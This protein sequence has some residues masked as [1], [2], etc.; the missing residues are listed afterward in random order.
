MEIERITT[1][2]AIAMMNRHRYRLTHEFGRDVDAVLED[3][4]CE[5]CIPS[6]LVIW[7]EEERY[8]WEDFLVYRFLSA[9][10]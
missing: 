10:S 1:E 6:L 3:T 4:C 9:Q 8:V 2:E 5:S 7:G